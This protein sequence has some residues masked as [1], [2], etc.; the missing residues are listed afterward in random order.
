MI[1]DEL[2]VTGGYPDGTYTVRVS[3]QEVTDVE[4]DIIE[5]LKARLETY[6]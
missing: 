3:E 4:P 1:N 6:E 2:L 5:S